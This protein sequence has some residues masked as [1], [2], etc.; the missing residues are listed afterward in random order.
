MASCA[1]GNVFPKTKE[2]TRIVIVGA[3]PSGIAA[4]TKLLEQGFRNVQIFEAEDRIGGRIKTV[5]F[6]DSFI[7][8]G[9][10]WCHGEQGNVVFE[11]VKD[12][13]VLDRTADQ[14]LHLVR[15]NKE[16]LS[17][18][19]TK[20][21]KEFVDAFDVSVDWEG[22]VGDRFTNN[23]WNTVGKDLD[24]TIAKEA[25]SSMM[26]YICTSDACDHLF[27]LSSRNYTNF[28]LADGD[29]NLSWRRR[30]FW[31]FLSLLLE[32]K[33]DQPGDQG[34]LKGYVHLNRRI[35][36][37]NWKGNGELTLRCWNGEIVTADHVI[38]TVS[39]GVLKEK[40][41]KL[42][43]PALPLAKVRAIEGLKLGTV[44]KF[45]M[46]F[47]K[48][49]F[50]ENMYN[51]AILWL[52]A[53]LLELRGSEFYWLESVCSF[54]RVDRQPT[55]LEGWI[56]GAH[57]RHMETLGE[58][59]VLE[60]LLWLFRKFLTFDVPRPKHFIRTQWHSNPNFR[61]SYSF[62]PTYADDLRTGRT[63]LASP[64]VD[65]TNG[66]P[67]VQ[68]AGEASSGNHWGTVHGATESGWREA[69]RL[70]DFYKAKAEN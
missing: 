43:V 54:H 34:C 64:L 39:L 27:E 48:H 65:V 38:C 36:E 7:D 16:I 31:Y 11:R 23:Y 1:V 18:E 41:E 2:T 6:A 22:S 33:E 52:E 10:Q 25:L 57:A 67:R 44:N 61:G 47:E 24:R 29:Q 68:F 55:L 19:Q 5:P 58:D 42:F 28:H 17:E 40:H 30:G 9:A 69:D 20:P 14:A 50:P 21:L 62:Y 56:I 66:R 3:G 63:D 32:A 35:A 46:E 26:K 15:S 51:V 49:P 8:L 45:I 59:K 4:A 12:L 60:G 53:D 13:D 70:I 37:I